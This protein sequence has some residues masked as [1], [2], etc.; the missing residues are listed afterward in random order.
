M[1][2]KRKEASLL[3]GA[4]KADVKEKREYEPDLKDRY[5]C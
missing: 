5:I 3:P 2:I 4:I 1:I